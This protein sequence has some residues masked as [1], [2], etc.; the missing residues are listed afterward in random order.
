MKYVTYARVRKISQSYSWLGIDL[1]LD[2]EL[3][4]RFSR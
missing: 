1:Q 2:I 3:Q 4:S